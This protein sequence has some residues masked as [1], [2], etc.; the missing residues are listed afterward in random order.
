MMDTVCRLA[1]EFSAKIRAMGSSI[2]SMAQNSFTSVSYT[3]LVGQGDM[4]Q[5]FMSISTGKVF[6]INNLV[7]IAIL[8]T[9]L[10]YTSLPGTGKIS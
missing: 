8:I 4:T 5:E 2:S 3:H 10:L 6:G 7:F 1:M 9:C